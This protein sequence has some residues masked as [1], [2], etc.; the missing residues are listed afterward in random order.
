MIDRL[1]RVDWLMLA[2]VGAIT[3]FHI[4]GIRQVPFHPDES[5]LLYQSADLERWLGDPLSLAWDESRTFQLEQEY[6]TLNPPLP[7][8]VLGIG[9]RL[10][11]FGPEAVAVDWDWSKTWDENAAAGALPSEPLLASARLANTLL[12]PISL[13]F[14]YLSGLKIGGRTTGVVA[15]VLLGSNALVLL[16]TRRAMAEAAVIMGVCLA[17]FSFLQAREK[18]WLAGLGAATA[19]LAKLST[20]PLAPV[21][22][23][24]AMFPVRNASRKLQGSLVAGATYLGAFVAEILVFDP[25]LWS[26]PIQAMV[27]VWRARLEFSA[28]QVGQIGAIAPTVILKSPDARLASLLGNVF[29]EPPQFAEV[30]NYVAHTAASVQVYLASPANH[31]LRGV[32]GGVMLLLCLLGVGVAGIQFP[33]R[34]SGGKFPLVALALASAAQAAALYAAIQVPFQ[35]YYMPLIP[36]VCLWVAFALTGLGALFAQWSRRRVNRGHT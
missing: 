34:T 33:H 17:V 11:G 22:L 12:L 3:A 1:R 30:G 32:A 27:A 19:L 35:R 29:L 16:H 15:V 13:V 10:A 14:L 24:L 9:R 7:K 26:H 31:L 28:T 8:I 18:P 2:I 21:G 5:S 20:A 4:W 23:V 25:L 6:R 36:F